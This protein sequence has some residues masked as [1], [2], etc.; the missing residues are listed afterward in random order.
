M[1]RQCEQCELQRVSPRLLKCRRCG[2]TEPYSC[3]HHWVPTYPHLEYGI[4]LGPP[5]AVNKVT[6]RCEDCGAEWPQ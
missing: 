5:D 2:H 6:A 3:R 1:T 4:P